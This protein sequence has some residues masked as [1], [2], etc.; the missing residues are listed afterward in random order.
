MTSHMGRYR[1][2]FCMVAAGNGNGLVGYG[3]AKAVEAKAAIRR[4]RNRAGQGLMY[5]QRHEDRTSKK[6]PNFVLLFCFLFFCLDVDNIL[7]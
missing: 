5:V 7:K 6:K 3:L 2:V 1:K 4:A